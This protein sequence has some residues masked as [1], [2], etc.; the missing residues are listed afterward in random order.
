[1]EPLRVL[2]LKATCIERLED[3]ILSGHWQIG[4]RL[5]PE[6]VLAAEMGISRPVLHDALVDLSVKGLVRIE[7]RRG[8]YVQDYRLSGSTALL[9]SL[10]S[11]K[12]GQLD[13]VLIQSLLDMRLLM[14]SEIAALAA[15]RRTS[16]QLAGLFNLLEREAQ[17]GLDSAALTE[18][19][20]SFHQQVAVASGNLVYPLIINSLKA[21]YT[22]LTGQF[23]QRYA[24]TKVVA[25]VA[26]LRHRL[27]DAIARQQ[28]GTAS[29]IMRAMLEHGE[30]YL[31]QPSPRAG[32]RGKFD[33]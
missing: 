11:F 19:D 25:E 7:P 32:R 17:P 6:R 26:A 24:G 21:V 5:P 9:A 10:L 16:E 18:L 14:E 27:V 33:Q 23:F 2:S 3:L 29:E 28:A 4:A 31:K 22:H 1:M 12:G 30:H 13:P 20:F 15:C 8:V